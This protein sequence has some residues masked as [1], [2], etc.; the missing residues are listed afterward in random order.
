MYMR[1][2]M[3]TLR[4]EHLGNLPKVKTHV[5]ARDHY[6]TALCSQTFDIN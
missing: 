6:T 1:F 3:K 2:F 4:S 5:S